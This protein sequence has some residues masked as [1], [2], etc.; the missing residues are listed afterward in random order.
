[1][2][3]YWMDVFKAEDKTTFTV[4]NFGNIIQMASP[5]ER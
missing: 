2:A 4:H 3:K 5:A 1:M